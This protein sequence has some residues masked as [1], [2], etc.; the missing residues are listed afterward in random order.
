[1]THQRSTP[2]AARTSTRPQRLLPVCLALATLFGPGLA[3][4]R[5][6]YWVG[7]TTSNGS[8]GRWSVGQ[9]WAKVLC[10][11]P[12]CGVGSMVYTTPEAGDSAEPSSKKMF[13]GLMSRCAMPS[14]WAYASASRMGRTIAYASPGERPPRPRR[15][16][17]RR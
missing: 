13:E 6:L 5:D 1:M 8:D 12:A 11:R 17:P 4:A 16:K 3:V 9:N 15:S 7:G 14:S 2:R 10:E